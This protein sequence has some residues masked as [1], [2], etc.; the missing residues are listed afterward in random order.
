M[1]NSLIKT[2]GTLAIMAMPE[3]LDNADAHEVYCARTRGC[4]AGPHYHP[5]EPVR[6]TLKFLFCPRCHRQYPVGSCCSC[7]HSHAHVTRGCAAGPHYIPGR[8][9]G[10]T[11]KFLFCPRCHR[12]HAEGTVC[13]CSNHVHVSPVQ[14]YQTQTTTTTTTT[15][16]TRT[17][18]VP[19]R[20]IYYSLP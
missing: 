16:T 15:T 11:L 13:I 1:K 9:I 14:T 5:G 19:A 6:N 4:A 10:N 8:P 3:S 7:S 20:Q 18:V 2:L 17:T 12:Q